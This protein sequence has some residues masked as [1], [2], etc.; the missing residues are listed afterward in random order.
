M[1]GVFRTPGNN[2][3]SACRNSGA[4][5]SA[6]KL[7]STESEVVPHRYVAEHLSIVFDSKEGKSVMTSL[8]RRSFTFYVPFVCN[9]NDPSTPAPV[10]R[11][12]RKGP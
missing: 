6:L 8:R 12:R 3:C 2:C 5:R 10:V 7:S 4:V 11:I 1:A 9:R